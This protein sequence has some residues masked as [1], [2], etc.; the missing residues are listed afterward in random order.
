MILR[1]PALQLDPRVQ[2]LWA[3]EWGLAALV[4]AGVAADARG[5]VRAGRRG[6]LGRHRRAASDGGRALGLVVL[7]SRPAAPRVSPLPLRDHG[8]RPVR[9]AGPAVQTMAGGAARARADGRHQAR[10]AGARVRARLRRGEHRVGEG[11]HRHPRA[12]SSAWP[13]RSWRSSR[14]GRGST[15]ER[16][17]GRAVCP[18]DR[19]AACIRSRSSCSPASG[20]A[21]ASCRSPSSR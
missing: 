12:R 6:S 17:R 3:L 11:R 4:C 21:R 2:R 18:P 7:G 16:E 1:D 9:R 15:R 20:S 19:P 5:P 13:T 10:A 8:A 14:A